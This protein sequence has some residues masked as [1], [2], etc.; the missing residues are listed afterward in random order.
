MGRW[1]GT[2]HCAPSDEPEQGPDQPVVIIPAGE[3]RITDALRHIEA[4]RIVLIVPGNHQRGPPS[5]ER[6]N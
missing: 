2:T 4:S 5:E 1:D 3:F 6:G